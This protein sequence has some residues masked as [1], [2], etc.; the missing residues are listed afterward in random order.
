MIKEEER[1]VLE[2]VAAGKVTPQE[3]NLLLDA[4]VSEARLSPQPEGVFRRWIWGHCSGVRLW[5]G[6]SRRRRYK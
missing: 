4:L 6:H 2:M 1:R 3:A 5:C